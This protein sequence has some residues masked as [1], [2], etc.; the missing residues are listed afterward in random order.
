M[1]FVTQIF[2]WI[3]ATIATML[4]ALSARPAAALLST[5]TV[6]LFT[7]NPVINPQTVLATLTA[8]EATFTGYAAAA[9]PALAGPINL[10]GATYGMH[11]EV[12]FIGGGSFSTPNTITG[13]YVT[14]TGN[15]ILYGAEMLT[16]PVAIAHTGDYLSIDVILPLLSIVPAA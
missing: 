16:T 3:Q 6:H 4:A 2:T 9:L 13:Y 7:G 15:T 11:G 14:D 10:P 1:F 12:D 5:P 8:L